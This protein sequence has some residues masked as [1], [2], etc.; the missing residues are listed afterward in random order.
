MA[1][2]PKLRVAGD[3]RAA[4][5][6]RATLIEALPKFRPLHCL[7]LEYIEPGLQTEAAEEALRVLSKEWC[8]SDIHKLKKDIT[9]AAVFASSVAEAE[10]VHAPAAATI[11]SAMSNIRREIGLI[12]RQLSELAGNDDLSDWAWRLS[13][14]LHWPST[15]QN[16]SAKE[17]LQ[18][19]AFVDRLICAFA[20]AERHPELPAPRS[21][22]HTRY[23]IH[24]L[25]RVWKEHTG[26][27]PARSKTGPF[28]RFVALVW[29]LLKSP[30]PVKDSGLEGW[31]GQR[32]EEVL[33]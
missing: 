22:P 27:R 26:R 19:L 4:S 13:F 7:S 11:S 9:E 2:K 12:Q 23:L 15:L 31:L 29:R 3:D 33:R 5:R 32:I 20:R 25:A 16:A 21:D 1:R 30:A 14:L 10:L 6:H 24:D 8:H 18:H 17:L 28:V